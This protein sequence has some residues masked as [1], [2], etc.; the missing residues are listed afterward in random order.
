M[1]TQQIQESLNYLIL[2]ITAFPIIFILV[3][4]IL[5][6][7]HLW[8]EITISIEYT[9]TNNIPD[10]SSIESRE[11]NNSITVDIDKIDLHTARKIAST[12]RKV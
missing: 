3:D 1:N 7:I 2:A 10:R 6:T 12:I 5:G 8:H 4:F 9:T 11:T